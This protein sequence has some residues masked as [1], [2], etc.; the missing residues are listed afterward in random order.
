MRIELL[1]C[2][3]HRAC[4]IIRNFV[5]HQQV[6]SEHSVP[7]NLVLLSSLELLKSMSM[8]CELWTSEVLSRNFRRWG[9]ALFRLSTVVKSV[10]GQILVDRSTN[11]I[12]HLFLI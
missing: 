8:M 3:K 4:K 6:R 11:I 12:I 5:T 7:M 1:V 9:G 2:H 10:I